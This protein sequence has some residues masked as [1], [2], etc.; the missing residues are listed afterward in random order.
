MPSFF[1]WALHSSWWVLRPTAQEDE[2]K[3]DFC[4]EAALRRTQEQNGGHH[5]RT[6]KRLPR[7]LGARVLMDHPCCV[8]AIPN[9][10]VDEHTASSFGVPIGFFLLRLA[11]VN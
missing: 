6:K 8:T 7:F 2:M 10:E 4:L 9:T 3:D 5:T 11:H 1:L